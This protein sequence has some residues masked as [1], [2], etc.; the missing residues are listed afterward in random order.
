MSLRT[1]SNIQISLHELITEWITKI[2][3]PFH[4]KNRTNFMNELEG[5]HDEF[6]NSL[7]H[8]KFFWQTLYWMNNQS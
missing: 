8:S 3:K 6:K 1:A 4:L 5:S 2:N 7:K